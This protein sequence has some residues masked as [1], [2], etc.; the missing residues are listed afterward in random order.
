MGQAE[1]E[2]ND[3]GVCGHK[4]GRPAKRDMPNSKTTQKIKLSTYFNSSLATSQAACFCASLDLL[5]VSSTRKK[6][7]GVSRQLVSHLRI[8]VHASLRR[9][10]RHVLAHRCHGRHGRSDRCLRYVPSLALAIVAVV[11]SRE[12][13]RVVI[14]LGALLVVLRWLRLRL[15]LILVLRL[16]LGRLLAVRLLRRIGILRIL[17]GSIRRRLVMRCSIRRRWLLGRVGVVMAKGTVVAK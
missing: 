6:L 2:I 12:A 14:H 9:I 13:A 17:V 5:L 11:H 4:R 15:I 7:V 16:R 1:L 8:L 10:A 3:G